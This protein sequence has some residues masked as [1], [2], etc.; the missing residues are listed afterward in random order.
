MQINIYN[1][2]GK[3]VAKEE[4]KELAE[5]TTSDKKLVSAAIV[6][7]LS[8]LR[9]PIAHTK[10]KGEVRGGGRKPWRQKGT[11]RARAGSIRS[12][13]WRGG[14]VIFG[15]RN[16]IN[17][18]KKINK[19][20]KGKALE[21]LIGD[22]IKSNHFIVLENF[23][24][25]AAKTKEAINL[26]KNILPVGKGSIL[27]ALSKREDSFLRAAKN[28]PYF[29]MTPIKSLNVYQILEADY[30]LTDVDGFKEIKKL[31]D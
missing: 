19:K 31:F 26:L 6:A 9:K 11:G 3:V 10:T 13:L 24:V 21:I 14:G 20:A 16:I 2:E 25:A 23:S 22:K 28:I 15:P 4:M 1:Q 12:P 27:V 30:L 7:Y 17:F 8:N 5:I 18:E 29:E